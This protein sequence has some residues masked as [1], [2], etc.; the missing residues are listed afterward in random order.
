MAATKQTPNQEKSYTQNCRKF[1]GIFACLCLTFSPTQCIVFRRKPFIAWLFSLQCSGLTVLSS[2]VADIY[3]AWLGLLITDCN[4]NIICIWGWSLLKRVVGIIMCV[5]ELQG[6]F[7]THR[8]L[9]AWDYGERNMIDHLRSWE[10]A[11]A[12]HFVKLKH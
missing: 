3:L 9:V 5:C 7:H 2:Q 1:Y 8:C 12:R 4:R 10:K 6:G 11:E